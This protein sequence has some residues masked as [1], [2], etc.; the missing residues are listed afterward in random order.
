LVDK[1]T[2][3]MEE[4][5]AMIK[6][7]GHGI[8]ENFTYDLMNW[9]GLASLVSSII[10]KCGRVDI[11]LNIA[12]VSEGKNIMDVDAALWDEVFTVNMRS[13]F[14]LMQEVGKHMIARGGGG[15]IV[16]VSSSAAYRASF[17]PTVYSTSKAGINQ[18]TRVMGHALAKHDI[19]VNAVVPGFTETAMTTPLPREWIKEGAL[20][21]PFKRISTPEDVAGVML[22]LCQPA[23]RQISGQM[24]HTSAGA[25]E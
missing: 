2:A 4:T 19:N 14:I 10:A 8:T 23:S 11:L 21:N 3:G 16:N 24:I 15:K 18:L 7:A 17:T 6:A 9:T 22:F 5:S 1:N 13:P 20:A 25:V 12:G